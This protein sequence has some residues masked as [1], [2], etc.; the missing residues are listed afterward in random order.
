VYRQ[1]GKFPAGENTVV[2]D[3]ALLNTTG[4]LYYQLETDKYSA[5]KKM[6]QGK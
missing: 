6:V 5:T 1:K 2:L 4:V 3:R